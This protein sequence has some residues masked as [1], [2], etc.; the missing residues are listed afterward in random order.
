VNHNEKF[1]N[2]KPPTCKGEKGKKADLN[3]KK[4]KKIWPRLLLLIKVLTGPVAHIHLEIEVGKK[5]GE[6]LK[7]EKA[8]A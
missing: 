3:K 1:K 2:L 5:G 7:E 4:R 6:N 8:I